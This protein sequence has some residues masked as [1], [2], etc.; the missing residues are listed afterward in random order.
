MVPGVLAG[1]EVKPGCGL[2]RALNPAITMA[3]Q[4]TIIFDRRMIPRLATGAT[5][6]RQFSG[7]S[8]AW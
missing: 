2:N 8:A 5:R 1:A 3:I 7:C 6:P 4:L